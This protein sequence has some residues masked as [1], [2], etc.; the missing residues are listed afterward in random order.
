MVTGEKMFMARPEEE[1]ERGLLYLRQ[2][3]DGLTA[4]DNFVFLFPGEPLSRPE[5]PQAGLLAGNRFTD[6]I[7][8]FLAHQGSADLQGR[9]LSKGAVVI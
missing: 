9:K 2:P 4:S 3:D 7:R 8:D 5:S 1:T 6:F